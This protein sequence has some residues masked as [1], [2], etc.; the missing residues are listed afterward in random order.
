M[1]IFL[2]ISISWK[3][4]TPVTSHSW[5]F[6][7]FVSRLSN[8]LWVKTHQQRSLLGRVHRL[9]LPCVDKFIPVCSS[10]WTHD[11]A[12]NTALFITSRWPLHLVMVFVHMCQ[13]QCVTSVFYN[14]TGV[15]GS[16]LTR[17]M[18]SPCLRWF[19]PGTPPYSHTPKNIQIGKCGN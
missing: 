9:R 19:P 10:Q 16:K 8:P 14:D 3:L 15:V 11:C 5:E 4:Y 12:D 17:G 2:V 18:F 6:V 7:T 1:E 13:P